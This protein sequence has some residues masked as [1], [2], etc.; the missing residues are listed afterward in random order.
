MRIVGGGEALGD[1]TGRDVHDR[2][3]AGHVLGDVE[4]AGGG[5]E[6]ET[7]GEARGRVAGG[8]AQADAVGERRAGAVPRVTIDELARGAGGVEGLPV[9]RE[10]EA[11]KRPGLRQMLHHA[12]AGEVHDLDALL[13]PAVQGEDHL[14]AAGR[15]RRPERHVAHGHAA[16]GGIE[17]PASG[18]GDRSDAAPGPRAVTGGE[19]PAGGERGGEEHGG[20]GSRHHV[21]I[22]VG[23]GQWG[24]D[25]GSLRRGSQRRLDGGTPNALRKTAVKWPWLEKPRSSASAE[26]LDSPCS[27]RESAG[28]R[29]GRAKER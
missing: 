26:R 16:S 19:G 23:G 21:T 5:G 15:R 10:D 17:T 22:L 9:G 2:E 4:P 6:G 12:A 27:S 1:T 18:K 13:A 11:E 29:G 28:A 3:R 14:A 20:G 24:V 7:G 8:G 25:S